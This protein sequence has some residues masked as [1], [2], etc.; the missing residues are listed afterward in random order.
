MLMRG[1]QKC[2]C[3][4]RGLPWHPYHWDEGSW[5][6]VGSLGCTEL[7]SPVWHY[8]RSGLKGSEGVLGKGFLAMGLLE[9][10]LGSGEL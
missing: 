3:A 4:R 6:G 1:Y 8:W 5:G 10:F 2:S 7:N 9:A